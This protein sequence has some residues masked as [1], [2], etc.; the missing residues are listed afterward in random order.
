MFD[1]PLCEGETVVL[2]RGNWLD[3]PRCLWPGE[4]PQ[5]DTLIGCLA[6]ITAI[7]TFEDGETY[8]D[9]KVEGVTSCVRWWPEYV[10]RPYQ[11]QIR[12]ASSPYQRFL[13]LEE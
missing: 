11:E 5:K 9:V 13:D 6:K 8:L 7:R 4:D 10:D 3:D 1:P 2:A 12:K